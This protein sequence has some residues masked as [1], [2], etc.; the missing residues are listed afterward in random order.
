MKSS[1]YTLVRN[2]KSKDVK[3]SVN[4]LNISNEILYFSVD[5]ATGSHFTPTNYLLRLS[6][7][8][9]ICKFFKNS[10][11]NYQTLLKIFYSRFYNIW[12]LFVFSGK[13]NL[14]YFILKNTIKLYKS[15]FLNKRNLKTITS[16]VQPNH[17]LIDLPL[18]A[19]GRN[20]IKMSSIKQLNNPLK[21]ASYRHKKIINNLTIND[22][23]G[24]FFSIHFIRTQRRYNKRRYSRVRAFSRPS[25]FAGISLSSMFV[26]SF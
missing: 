15:L 26:G 11:L 12:L 14:Y 2:I 8:I 17:F 18:S 7:F 6:L 1:T 9:K 19:T 25:F 4:Y 24:N 21:T 13:R 22:F 23:G 16:L 3:K 20:V 10:R 5:N